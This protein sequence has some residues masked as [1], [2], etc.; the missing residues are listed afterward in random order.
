[1]EGNQ[2]FPATV[3]SCDA[4][5]LTPPTWAYPH[6]PGSNCSITGGHVY[7]G[8]HV[9]LREAYVYGDLCSGRIWAFREPGTNTLLIDTNKLITSFG[10]DEA[11][12]LYFLTLDQQIWRFV[13]PPFHALDVESTGDGSGHISSLPT[14]IA[15]GAACSATF[16]VGEVVA[17]IA[18]SDAGSVFLGWGGACSGSGACEVTMAQ[19]HTVTADFGLGPRQLTVER[20]GAG[21]GLVRS[22]SLEIDCGLTCSALF[23]AFQVLLWRPPLSPAPCLLVGSSARDRRA[24]SV[25]SP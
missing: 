8:T 10:L 23:D 4:T 15:C 25:R 13:P 21:Q 2:C 20:T 12:D 18:E 24:Q 19:A 16:P 3:T 7:H 14:G 1:M 11:G 17:L 22:T 9:W 6:D 5:G